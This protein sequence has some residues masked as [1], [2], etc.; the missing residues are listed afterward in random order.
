MSFD[1]AALLMSLCINSRPAAPSRRYQVL[2][3]NR[4]ES[5]L[6]PQHTGGGSRDRVIIVST[7]T[8]SLVSYHYTV[9]RENLAETSLVQSNIKL[10]AQYVDRIEQTIID[11]DRVL[12]EM[13]DVNEP[14]EWPTIVANIQKADLNVDEVYFLRLPYAYPVYPTYV[15]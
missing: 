2:Q 3:Y 8:L 11:N 6:L 1:Y 13:I 7:G 15:P 5:A 10:V 4:H 14:S 12:S 9:G